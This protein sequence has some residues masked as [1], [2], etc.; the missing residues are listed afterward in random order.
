M[1]IDSQQLVRTLV[2]QQTPLLAYIW[3]IVRDEDLAEDVYQDVAADA[4]AK[5]D[6][7]RDAEHLTRWLRQA[8]RFRAIDLLRARKAGALI[9]DDGVLDSL[10]SDWDSRAAVDA[11]DVR[12]SLRHCMEQLS[13]YVRK[14]IELRYAQNLTGDAL[15]EAIGKPKNTV[16]T[17]LSRA[18]RTLGECVRKQMNGEDN[19]V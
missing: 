18:H 4:V 19:D 3:A 1:P 10:E 11:R 15:A 6:T 12:R 13:P 9:F 7:I 8:A 5:C 2:A 17:A 16:Y 14:I